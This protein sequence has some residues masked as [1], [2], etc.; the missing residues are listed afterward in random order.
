MSKILIVEDDNEIAMLE[1]DYLSMN[2]IDSDIINDGALALATLENGDYDLIL[3]DIMLPNL[4]GFDIC[5][6]IRDK[7]DIPILMVTAKNESLDKLRGLGIGANDFITKP[8]DPAELVARVKSQLDNYKRI[9]NDSDEILIKDIK[10]ISNNYQVFKGKKE[11]KLPNKEFELLN[12]LAKHPNIVFSK[13]QLFETIWGLDSNGDEATITVHI[14][15]IR[16]KIEDNP[17]KP[18]IIETVWGAGYRLNK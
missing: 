18:Q 14:N 7:V 13:E 4:N 12:F 11:L 10:I 9:K 8:F 6:L 3:L 2:Q 17:T 16:E 15:R 5:R 1:R